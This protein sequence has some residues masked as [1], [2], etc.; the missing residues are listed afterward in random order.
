MMHA[1][2]TAIP[3]YER[4]GYRIEG[5]EFVQQTIPHVIMVKDI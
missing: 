3:F 2:S 1:R 5:G 4:L